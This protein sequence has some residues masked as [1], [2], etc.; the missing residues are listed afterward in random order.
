MRLSTQFLIAMVA[1]VLVTAATIAL[2]ALVIPVVA[3]QPSVVIATII[4]VV[5]GSAFALLFSRSMAGGLAQL[6]N[7]ALAP[8]HEGPAHWPMAAPGEIGILARSFAR[9][10]GEIRTHAATIEKFAEWQRNDRLKD[11]FVS[12]VSHELRTPLTSIAG[13]LGLLA[14]GAAGKMPEPMMRLLKIAHKNS[15]RLVRLINDILDIEKME[16]GKVVFDLKG[17]EAL[18]L[19]EQSIE[20]NRGFSES[21]GVRIALDPASLGA[22]VRADPDRLMQVVTNLLSNAI[23]FSPRDGEVVAAITQRD[24]DVRITVRDHGAGIPEDF[25]SRIFEKFAQADGGDARQ[26]GGTGLGLSIVKQIVTMLGGVVSF[27]CP[28]GGG[29]S[30]HVDLPRW[31]A[32]AEFNTAPARASPRRTLAPDAADPQTAAH[33]SRSIA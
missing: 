23:K 18:A 30:F 4:A 6:T 33:E 24:D 28:P 9:M 2:P 25:R 32:P 1:L 8:S 20:A 19:V 7:A 13:S 27:E 31:E 21:Y 26:K 16:S 14:G 11:E 12:T 5:T 29:T 10:A 22:F 3:G 15:E 17:V